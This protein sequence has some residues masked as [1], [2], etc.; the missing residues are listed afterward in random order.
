MAYYS[1]DYNRSVPDA[2]SP[3]N[4]TGLLADDLYLIAHHEVT[5]KPY[6]QPRALGSGL[7]GGLLAE[8]M[9]TGPPAVMLDRGCLLPVQ[10]PGGDLAVRRAGFDEPVRRHVLELV[11]SEPT[12]RPVRDWLMFLGQTAAVEVAGRL[13]RSGFLIRP[14]SRIP[15]RSRRPVPPDSDWAHCALLRAHAALDATRP[16]ASY[17]ALL[18]GLTFACGLGFRFANLTVGPTRTVGEAIT[19]LSPQARE[20][21]SHVQ[22]AT[23]T[24]LLSQRK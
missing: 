13:E 14:P 10:L 23:D 3:L 7:A 22:V 6:L 11:A 1:G 20:L 17:A 9:T 16:P 2:N 18:A 5:G 19:V 24:T 12:P 8:L 21:I 4:G 15:G